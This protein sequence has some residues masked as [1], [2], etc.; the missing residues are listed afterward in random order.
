MPARVYL[1]PAI[2]ALALVV[3][4]CGSGAYGPPTSSTGTTV[5]TP[6]TAPAA[7]TGTTYI[8]LGDDATVAIGSGGCGTT[9]PSVNCPTNTVS[10]AG[11]LRTN[12]N[13]IAVNGYAQLLATQF[14]T[15]HST[16]PFF[17]VPLGVTGALVGSEPVIA[18][19]VQNDIVTNASQ[20]AQL[21]SL[22]S[23]ARA[24]TNRIVISVFAGINDVA[25][26]YFTTQCGG[27]TNGSGATIAAPCGASG[28]TLP[29]SITNPRTGSLYNGYRAL[30]TA[31]AA[32]APDAVLIV[33]VPDLSRFPFFAQPTLTAAQQ[34]TLN[35]DSTLANAALQAAAADAGLKFA[36]TDLFAAGTNAPGSFYSTAAFSTDHFHYTEPGY[37][38]IDGAAVAAFSA[39]Y[40][41]F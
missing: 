24:R 13:G 21:P 14:N 34:N 3:A 4:A 16:Q 8:A 5:A 25:D 20:V 7:F 15:L 36:F 12:I 29:T 27:P 39:F 1:G 10:T 6:T 33:G 41:T 17:F 31:V 35:A 9:L 28:T 30:F 2:L 38:A 26:A 11:T 37:A 40:P 18:T 32:S 23:S 22:I 19:P